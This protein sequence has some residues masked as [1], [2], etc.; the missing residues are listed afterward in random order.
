MPA[1]A[2][3]LTVTCNAGFFSYPM[4]DTLTVFGGVSGSGGDAV[5]YNIPASAIGK[6]NFQA[7]QFFVVNGTAQ[8]AVTINCYDATNK[9][10]AQ[11]VVNNVPLAT[12]THTVLSGLL[13][14]AGGQ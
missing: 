5:P 12:N 9:L 14:G 10:I 3:K 6:S 13:F 7:S 8:A 4:L 11:S 2:S 1:N